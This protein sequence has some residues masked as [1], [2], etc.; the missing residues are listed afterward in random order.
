MARTHLHWS[1]NPAHP[2]IRPAVRAVAGALCGTWSSITLLPHNGHPSASATQTSKQHFG[3]INGLA[4]ITGHR[5]AAPPR[6]ACTS[7]DGSSRTPS[8]SAI[9]AIGQPLLSDG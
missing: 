6:S 9:A 8:A 5:L 1:T 4:Y 2:G 7:P 3:K